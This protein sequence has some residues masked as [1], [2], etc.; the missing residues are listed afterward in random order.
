M[1]RLGTIAI[2]AAV[3]LTVATG[4]SATVGLLYIMESVV[5]SVAISGDIG[6]LINGEQGAIDG[7]CNTYMWN[8]VSLFLG[9]FT[10]YI[11]AKMA[12]TGSPNSMGLMGERLAGIEP[13]DKKPIHINNRSR[14]PDALTPD[15]LIE[16]KNVKYISNTQQLK[17]FADYAKLIERSL[18]LFVRPTTRISR[19]VKDAGWIIHYLW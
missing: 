5:P 6:Y 18:H 11:I 9:S 17:D 7:M 19:S 13:K 3:T 16:V 4:G 10:Q 1:P 2:I 14:V 8:G 15:A 12:T